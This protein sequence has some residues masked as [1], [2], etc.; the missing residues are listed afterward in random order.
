MF[1]VIVQRKCSFFRKNWVASQRNVRKTVFYANDVNSIRS[2]NFTK[3]VGI[4]I[5]FDQFPTKYFRS[6]S[7]LHVEYN[8][9]KLSASL[10]SI[11]CHFNI[12]P[13]FLPYSRF[14]IVE[15]FVE[16]QRLC[17]HQ[18]ENCG[19]YARI[20]KLRG[21]GWNEFDNITKQRYALKVA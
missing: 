9:T 19:R 10:S 7:K 4:K 6:F 3:S 21:E 16:Q 14:Q 5:R 15:P 13:P 12:F 18:C 8:Q 17:E 20:M 2:R 11:V 1:Y